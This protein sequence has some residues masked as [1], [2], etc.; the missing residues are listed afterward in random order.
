MARTDTLEHYLTDVAAAIKA[1]LGIQTPILASAFDTAIANIPSGLEY[2]TGTYTPTT[3]TFKPTISFANTHATLPS[4]VAIYDTTNSYSSTSNS[5]YS[6]AYIDANTLTG[7]VLYEN[8]NSSTID[9]GFV[10]ALYRASNADALV[11]YFKNLNHS[12]SESGNSDSTYPRY[13]VS[14]TGFTP[15]SN[16]QTR[17]WKA[18]RTYKWIAIWK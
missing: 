2:E 14:E 10:L 9:Y 8:S 15:S 16:S 12:A 1:K 6:F 13:W 5:N 17:T 7:A 18:N 3:D 11:T 4:V